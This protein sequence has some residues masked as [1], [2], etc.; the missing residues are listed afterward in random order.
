MIFVSLMLLAGLGLFAH[1]AKKYGRGPSKASFKDYMQHYKKRSIASVAT[2]IAAVVTIYASADFSNGLTG[3]IAGLA[4]LAGY[5]GD[6]AVNKGP[7]E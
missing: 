4:F 3:Q 2:A 1:W 7:G 6:S 5:A